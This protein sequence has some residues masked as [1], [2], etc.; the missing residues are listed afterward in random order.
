M[1]TIAIIQARMSST[2]LPNKV[3]LTIKNK[4]LLW[5]V[6]T[7]CKWAKKI[8]NVIVATSTDRSDDPIKKFCR[9]E[10][11]PI[12]RGPLENVLERY[13]LSAIRHESDVIVR[14]TGDCPLIDGTL[15]DLGLTKFFEEKT[16]YLS[17]I[18]IRTFPRGFDFEIFTFE[19]LETTYN[20]AKDIPE[21]E[22]VTPYIYRNNPGMFRIADFTQPTDKSK[23]RITVDTPEDFELIK[24]L[25]EKYHADSKNYKEIISLLDKHPEISRINQHIEQKHYGR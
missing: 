12:I 2:R 19:A 15:L 4:P 3:L 14:I 9:N 1:N 13:Y 25:I 17:N 8:Q 24:I 20:N 11:I 22:H 10:K 21:K 5:Y 16:D 6:I 7:R 23:Y 18:T